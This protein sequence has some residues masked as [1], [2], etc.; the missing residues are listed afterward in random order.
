[1]ALAS[2]LAKHVESEVQYERSAIG[3]WG[4]QAPHFAMRW[5]PEPM[6]TAYLVVLFTAIALFSA[7][8]YLNELWRGMKAR[9]PPSA[10]GMKVS[11]RRVRA[12]EA[13]FGETPRPA[14]C[15][16]CTFVLILWIHA[17]GMDSHGK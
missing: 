9:K 4:S 10:K 2:M 12:H 5:K 3:G 17:S 1:M 13:T 7:L 16:M 15:L 14:P 6:P 11:V 8:P